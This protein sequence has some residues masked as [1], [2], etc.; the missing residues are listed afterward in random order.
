MDLPACTSDKEP[1]W[2]IN[3]DKA[4]HDMVH[5]VH[6]ADLPASLKRFKLQFGYHGSSAGLAAEVEFQRI[7]SYCF[8]PTKFVMKLCAFVS[9]RK[10]RTYVMLITK[11]VCSLFHRLL[12][13]K[14][15]GL[16]SQD[17]YLDVMMVL[18]PVSSVF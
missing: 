9:G 5:H 1:A 14:I 13:L 11:L 2:R 4:I 16:Y 8:V 6:L 3:V 12:A 10:Y 17:N 18:G 15:I 7:T